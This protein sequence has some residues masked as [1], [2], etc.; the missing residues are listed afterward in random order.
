M[1]VAI[2]HPR[3]M[4]AMPAGFFPSRCTVEAKTATLDEFGDQLVSWLPVP[5]I[6][7]IACAKAPLTALERQAAG[8][9]ATDQVWHVLLSGAYPTITTTHRAVV[10]SETFDIDGVETDQTAT[11]TRLRVRSVTT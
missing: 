5:A 8:Y 3:L 4:A 2:V 6:V 9:T 1:T 7:D 10:D 11:V